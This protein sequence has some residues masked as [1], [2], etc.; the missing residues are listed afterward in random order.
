MDL[1]LT[2]FIGLRLVNPWALPNEGC[3]LCSSPGPQLMGHR[4]LHDMDFCPRMLLSG[5]WVCLKDTCK[6]DITGSSVLVTVPD[7]QMSIQ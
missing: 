2:K 4:L 3:L 7:R 6:I 5:S 1:P